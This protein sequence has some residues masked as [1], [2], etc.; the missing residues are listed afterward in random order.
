MTEKKHAL[1]ATADR[2]PAAALTQQR[3]IAVCGAIFGL[4]LIYGV[5]FAHPEAI[6]NAAHDSRHSFAFPCH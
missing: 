2:A 1:S 3:M 6:H 5:G 4:F